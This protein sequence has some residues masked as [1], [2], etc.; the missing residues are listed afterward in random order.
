MKP[1]DEPRAR[2]SPRRAVA[3][4]GFRA[5][6]TKGWV[7]ASPTLPRQT[8]HRNLPTSEQASLAVTQPLAMQLS[9]KF[10]SFTLVKSLTRSETSPLKWALLKSKVIP[11]RASRLDHEALFAG[12]RVAAPV[13]AT[14]SHNMACDDVGNSLPGRQGRTLPVCRPDN[15]PR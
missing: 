1:I 3:P 2:S 15:G 9:T 13:R 10:S 7:A 5:S 11:V 6:C 12:A 8:T 4:F 14:S